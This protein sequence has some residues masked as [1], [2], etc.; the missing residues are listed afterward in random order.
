MPVTRDQ[1][2][3]K[4]ASW[5]VTPIPGTSWDIIRATFLSIEY[6]CR[7]FL[8]PFYDNDGYARVV[9]TYPRPVIYCNAKKFVNAAAGESKNSSAV[10]PMREARDEVDDEA[11][12]SAPSD[13]TASVSTARYAAKG[14]LMKLHGQLL[15]NTHAHFAKLQGMFEERVYFPIGGHVGEGSYGVVHR[16]TMRRHS[17]ESGCMQVAVKTVRF[18]EFTVRAGLQALSEVVAFAVL[19]PHPNV[20]ELLDASYGMNCCFLV[21]PWCDG[22]VLDWIKHRSILPIEVKYAS[23]FSCAGLIIHIDTASSIRI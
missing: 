2:K 13:G 10:R 14:L 1:K 15:T 18:K 8:A 7:D 6:K 5:E 16:G 9:L 11:A 12:A 3:D 17:P 4:H 20:I 19:V 21:F 23:A 22:D